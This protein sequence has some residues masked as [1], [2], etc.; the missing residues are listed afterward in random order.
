M[1]F[2]VT[3]TQYAQIHSVENAE[4]FC[5][6]SSIYLQLNLKVQYTNLTEILTTQT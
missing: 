2:I 6:W 5:S 3:V 4:Q 1:D